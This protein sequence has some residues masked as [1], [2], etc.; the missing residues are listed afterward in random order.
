VTVLAP[1]EDPTYRPAHVPQDGRIPAAVG[2]WGKASQRRWFAR[3]GRELY[4]THGDD[5]YAGFWV[6][7]PAHRGLCCSGCLGE[8]DEGRYSVD[9]CCCRGANK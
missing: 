8:R 7:S 4:A 6:D 5:A 9:G 2:R 1:L 3:F